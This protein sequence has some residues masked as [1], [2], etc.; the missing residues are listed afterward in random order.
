MKRETYFVTF[1]DTAITK[2]WRMVDAEW[3]EEGGFKKPLSLKSVGKV[4]IFADPQWPFY[5]GM[6]T[7]ALNTRLRG[8]F[9]TTPEKKVN[10]FS[11]YRFKSKMGSAFLHVFMGE[12]G[13]SWEEKDAKCIEAEVVFRI[14][15][16]GKWPAYQT[17]IHFSSP[18]KHHTSAADSI[19]NH[20]SKLRANGGL[21]APKS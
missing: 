8:G 17:E 16:D 21:S 19:I 9:R 20:F 15:Q 6:T 2:R 14:R 18:E 5:V 4:Y 3:V 11:G 13:N 10:G 12:D 1:T 7:Q